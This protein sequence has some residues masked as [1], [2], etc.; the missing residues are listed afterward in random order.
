MQDVV[1]ELNRDGARLA[2][3]AAIKARAG[4]RPPPLR[5]RR[6]RPH[7]P[8]RVAVA[9]RQ[10]PRL[11]RRNLRRVAGR[12]RRAD[13]RP[14]RR[15]RRP[16]S[17]R[18]DLRH[19]ERQ[20]GHLRLRGDL[21]RARK[22]AAADDL[23]HDH[24]PL[25]TH[26][27]RPNADRFLALGPPCAPLHHR[28]QLRPRSERDARTSGGDFRRGRYARLRLSQRRPAQRLRPVRREPRDDGGRDRPLRPRRARQHRR[29]LLRLDARPHPRDRRGGPQP[30]AARDSDDRA[31]DAAFRSRAVHAHR[32]H[33]LRQCRRADECHRLGQIPQAHH[34]RRLYRRARG[35]PRPGGQRRANHRHQYGRGPY[36]LR[37]RR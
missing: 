21:R 36:R 9:R 3:R 7:Q 37:R 26:A 12:L 34:R 24:R 22:P 13:T 23:G 4:G 32:R 33:P 31:A 27:L 10:Q 1:Y 8:H 28:P 5:R 25:G 2:R 30:E 17:D 14:H 6:A 29:R 11:S 35:R 18:N 19:A 15:R 20:G 16:H